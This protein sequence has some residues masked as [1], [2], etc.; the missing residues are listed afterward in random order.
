MRATVIHGPGDVRLEDVPDPQLRA[1]S[2]AVVRVVASCICGS[3]LW[4]YRGAN[5]FDEPWR[6]GH[7]FVGVVEQIGDEVATVGVGDFVIA[8]F[9]WSDGT[10]RLCRRGVQTS[11]ENGGGWGGEDADGNQ[12]DAGQGERVRVPMADGT[13]VATPAEPDAAL[14]PSLLTLSDVM[15]TGHH[16]AMAAGVR[17]GSTVAVVGDGAVGLCGV[18]AAARLGASTIVAMSRHEPRQQVAKQ[19]GATHIVAERGEAGAATAREILDGIG[20][21]CVLECVGTKES[22]EQAFDVTRDGGVVGY[23]GVPHGVELPIRRM[24]GSNL[25]IHGGVA[26]VRTYLPELLDDVWARRIDPGVVF[27]STLPLAQVADGYTAMDERRAIK[28]LLE[29]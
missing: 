1:D 6:I 19:F 9:V 11:C 4:P 7:E 23:V 18:L 3:D 5:S 2:D 21:D 13:L 12:V 10:C 20:A 22:M 28:V 16:A 29:P 25:S 14:I 8:P 17:E 26:P 24:F 15:G 27:D